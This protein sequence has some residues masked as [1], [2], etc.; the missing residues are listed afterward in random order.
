MTISHRVGLCGDMASCDGLKWAASAITVR[1]WEA[2]SRLWPKIAGQENTDTAMRDHHNPKDREASK[3]RRLQR[4]GRTMS[5][6]TECDH[7]VVRL[8]EV[9][10]LI[11]LADGASIRPIVRLKCINCGEILDDAD[12]ADFEDDNRR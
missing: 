12:D 1:S 2:G 5:K 8:V 7:D 9:H 6:Q 3:A 10:L 11:P 4:E